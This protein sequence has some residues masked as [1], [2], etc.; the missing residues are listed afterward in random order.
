MKPPKP[1]KELASI[2]AIM[3]IG[4]WLWQDIRV[5]LLL[6]LFVAPP[7]ILYWYVARRG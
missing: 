1:I 3:L 2:G 4:I 5:A 7:I 6:G